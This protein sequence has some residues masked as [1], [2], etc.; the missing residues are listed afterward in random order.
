ML[1]GDLITSIERVEVVAITDVEAGD[2]VLKHP[3]EFMRRAPLA[4]LYN[5]GVQLR[6][7]SAGS[8]ESR[9]CA[10]IDM[11]DVLFITWQLAGCDKRYGNNC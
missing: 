4:R 2:R 9:Q 5:S 6:L 7:R 10:V 3:I 11:G 1:F 8:A